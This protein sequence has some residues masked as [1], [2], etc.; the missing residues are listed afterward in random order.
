M[1]FAPDVD[2][3]ADGALRDRLQFLVHHCNAAVQCIQRS[4]D[5][6]LLPLINNLAF[7]HVVDTEHTLH[8]GGFAG[9]VLAHQRM[10]GTGL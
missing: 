3:L 7:V 1:Q 9:A 2:I 10:D 5:L 6:N 8:Q 4:L